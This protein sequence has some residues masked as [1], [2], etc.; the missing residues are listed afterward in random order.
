MRAEVKLRRTIL[1]GVSAKES[2]IWEERRVSLAKGVHVSAPAANGSITELIMFARLRDSLVRHP[3]SGNTID[4]LDFH[5]A[6]SGLEEDTIPTV[7]P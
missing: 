7:C 6:K 2:V 3:V 1:R 5:I 4:K